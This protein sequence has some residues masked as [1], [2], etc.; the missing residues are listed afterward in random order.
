[1]KRIM[2]IYIVYL[3][4][5]V[6][7]AQMNLFA[8]PA[9]AN[10]QSLYVPMDGVLN[11]MSRLGSMIQQGN[12][13]NRQYVDQLINAVL[14]LKT[15]TQEKQF[16]DAMDL[17]FKRLKNFDYTAHDNRTIASIRQEIREMDIGIK[18][19]ISKYNIRMRNR[20]TSSSENY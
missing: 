11:D 19:E 7:H 20:T 15:Q 10:Y 12:E 13:A 3:N 5:Y 17:Y 18:E 4:L 9:E 14:Q 2:C 8:K 16:L 1:M 6:A